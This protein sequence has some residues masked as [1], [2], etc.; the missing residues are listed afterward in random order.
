MPYIWNAGPGDYLFQTEE[1]LTT[2]G[3][4]GLFLWCIRNSN[5]SRNSKTILVVNLITF[6]VPVISVLQPSS[7]FTYSS[8]FVKIFHWCLSAS[9]VHFYELNFC[10]FNW[11][12][13]KIWSQHWNWDYVLSSTS[14]L[15]VCVIPLQF[16]RENGINKCIAFLFI[17]IYIRW[18]E[19]PTKQTIGCQIFKPCVQFLVQKYL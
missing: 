12:K 2:Y 6:E 5:N 9:S 19:K 10:K 18:L 4:F 16:W 11:I 13:L 17:L 14:S 8:V 7:S 1:V 3:V 15:Y